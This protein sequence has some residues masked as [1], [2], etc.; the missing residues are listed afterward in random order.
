MV[1]SDCLV[2]GGSGA[3]SWVG[4]Y[5]R[6]RDLLTTTD[7]SY[8]VN[9]EVGPARFGSGSFVMRRDAGRRQVVTLYPVTRSRKET[10]VVG[11]GVIAVHPRDDVF[12]IDVL[13]QLINIGKLAWVPDSVVLGLPTGWKAFF[14]DVGE[15][16]LEIDFEELVDGRP[17]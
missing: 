3:I 11:R 12:V 7:Y 9:V 5:C 1:K 10:H 13:Y 8:S 16:R 17:A 2:V 15:A 4:L 6:G 14:E